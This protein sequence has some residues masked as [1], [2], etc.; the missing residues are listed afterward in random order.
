MSNAEYTV[1]EYTVA[2]ISFPTHSARKY[3]PTKTHLPC[4]G[5]KPD[6]TIRPRRMRIQD[7]P[8]PDIT[9]TQRI[10]HELPTAPTSAD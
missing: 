1:A 3:V 6:F 7:Q 9:D 5:I 4:V 10:P 2:N 8:E